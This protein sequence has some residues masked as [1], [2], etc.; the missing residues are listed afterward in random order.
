MIMKV[1]VRPCIYSVEEVIFAGGHTQTVCTAAI[2]PWS[3]NYAAITDVVLVTGDI[4]QG[5]KADYDGRCLSYM[6]LSFIW[7]RN[8][9]H[10]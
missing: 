3:G 8:K 1:Y 9:S 6:L 4:L 2:G 10:E 7:N 5:I